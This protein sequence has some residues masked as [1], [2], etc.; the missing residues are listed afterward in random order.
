LHLVYFNS[1]SRP[2][3]FPAASYSTLFPSL[4]FWPFP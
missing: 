2:N 1:K 3:A 4:F